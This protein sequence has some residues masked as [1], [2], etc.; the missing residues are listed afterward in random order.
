MLSSRAGAIYQQDNARPHTARLSQ[1]CLQG[2]DVLPWPARSPDLSPIEHV[3]TRWEGNCSPRRRAFGDG[4]V[5]SGQITTTPITG[6]HFSCDER[7]EVNSYGHFSGTGG[8]SAHTCAG[9]HRSKIG[10]NIMIC[11]KILRVHITGL[12]NCIHTYIN[13][14]QWLNSPWGPRPTVSISVCVILDPEVHERM[15]RSGGQSGTKPPV[16]SSQASLV[17]ISRP[18]EGMKG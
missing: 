5:H 10:T 12:P 11:L 3:W 1:Q 2:Y 16:L 18:T 9:S 17:L 8:S 4:R 15:F 13:L 14:S 6:S 7:L